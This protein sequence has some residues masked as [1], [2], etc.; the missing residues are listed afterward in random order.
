MQIVTPQMVEDVAWDG[1]LTQANVSFRS[2]TAPP[3]VSLG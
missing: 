1:Q 3:R 2:A